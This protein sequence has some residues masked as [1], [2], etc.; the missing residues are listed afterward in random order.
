MLSLQEMR[1]ATRYSGLTEEELE[2]AFKESD[3][4][5]DGKVSL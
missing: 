3:C 2:Q 5:K 4:N 1:E